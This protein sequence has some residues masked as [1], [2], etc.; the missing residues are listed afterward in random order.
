MYGVF[1]S[2]CMPECRCLW[3]PVAGVTEGQKTVADPLQLELQAA[4]IHPMWVQELVKAEASLLSPGE[5]SLV[6]GSAALLFCPTPG[7]RDQG[8]CLLKRQAKRNISSLKVVLKH[9]GQSYTKVINT[10]GP[11]STFAFHPSLPCSYFLRA[12]VKWVGLVSVG[13]IFGK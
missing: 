4:G 1:A 6:S 7:P 8:Q 11:I 10:Q 13:R 9:F 12:C 5:P 2:A 3:S